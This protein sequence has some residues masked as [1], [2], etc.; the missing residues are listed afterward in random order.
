MK[1]KEFLIPL[2]C[3][4]LIGAL[5]GAPALAQ[6]QEET[7][8]ATEEEEREQEEAAEEETP[9]PALS[10]EMTITATRVETGLMETPVAVT[11]FEQDELDK[12][13]VHSADE[14]ASLVP[15]MDIATINGQST[16]IISM[17][18]IR[19]TNETELGDPAVGVHLDG[20]YSPR[21]QGILGLMFDNER[22]EVLRGPQGTL[23]GRNSPVGNINIISARPDPS[24]FDSSVQA[25]YGNYNTYELQSMVNVPITD[26]FAV[27]FAGRLLQADS[28]VD[29]F[30]DPNQYDQRFIGDRV[31]GAPVIAPDS[32]GACDGPECAS[33]TQ[34]SNWW[35]DWVG[36]DNGWTGYDIRALVPADSDD[37]YYNSDEWAFRFSSLWEPTE[38]LSLNL[39]YQRYEN[40]SAGGIDL[41]NCEKLRGRPVRNEDGEI[42]GTSDCSNLFP[43]DD[44]YQAV[45][46]VPGKFQ[47]DIQYLRANLTWDL[48]PELRFVY[49]GG[50]E[51]QERQSAQD[52]EQSLN[53]WDGAMFFLP[54]TG[55]D[56]WMHEVQLQSYGDKKF[57]WIA[58]ANVFHEKTS[59]F[60]FYDNPINDKAFWAQPDRSTDA[61]SVFTQGTY[62]FTPKWHMTLG[63]RH[64][65]ETKEDVGGRT[66]VC[67]N[68]NGCAPGWWMRETLNSLPEDYFFVPAVYPEFS[69]NDNMGSWNHNDYRIGI[70]YDLSDN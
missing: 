39:S 48:S 13:G 58:G 22:V 23:F 10:E 14:L 36:A 54:G 4:L 38:N 46:N 20:I 50:L 55:S 53:A 56:S 66:Y 15:N 68:D 41:V 6:N 11:A 19:S 60:G 9:I 25:S 34:H 5:G 51:D 27:R 2:F 1:L 32:F 33:R 8:P 31:D 18:G 21:M 43:A 24:G 7:P 59:T 45:V 28:Y 62:S 35:I 12:Q 63:L 49:L 16:P 67:N 69:D 30:W 47:L 26:N 37:F 65:D 57:N 17:R 64:S 40:D 3:A 29:G 52:M 44:T 42:I 61:W 70:D